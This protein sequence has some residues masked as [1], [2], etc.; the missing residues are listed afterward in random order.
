[1]VSLPMR[2]YWHPPALLWPDSRAER[3][4]DLGRDW[5]FLGTSPGLQALRM[6]ALLRDLL[7]QE[8]LDPCHTYCSPLHFSQC[9]QPTSQLTGEGGTK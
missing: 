8:A 4:H 1:M 5:V 6:K 7:G 9:L 2:E 3:L